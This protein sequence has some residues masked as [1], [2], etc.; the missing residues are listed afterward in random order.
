M[1]ICTL[2]KEHPKQALK[3]LSPL[4]TVSI[5]L[6]NTYWILFN[7][8]ASSTS[9]WQKLRLETVG[10]CLLLLAFCYYGTSSIET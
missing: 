4:G 3:L 9:S 10:F 6:K 5:V 7:S 8:I 2:I 1:Y